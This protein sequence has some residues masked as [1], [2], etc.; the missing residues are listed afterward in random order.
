MKM[1]IYSKIILQIEFKKLFLSLEH[2][3]VCW[4]LLNFQNVVQKLSLI[5]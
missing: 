4:I 1:W 5:S 2:G 3:M